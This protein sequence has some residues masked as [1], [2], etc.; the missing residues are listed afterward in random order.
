MRPGVGETLVVGASLLDWDL[1]VVIG[2]VD[3]VD[4][5]RRGWSERRPGC[6]WRVGTAW[7]LGQPAVDGFRLYTSTT[8]AR[9]RLSAG[10]WPS[11]TRVH[12]EVWKRRRH[13]SDLQR[14]LTSYLC[15]ATAATSTELSTGGGKDWGKTVFTG[16][17]AAG[18]G[19]VTLCTQVWTTLW[20]DVDVDRPTPPH[21]LADGRWCA[22]GRTPATHRRVR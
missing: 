8:Q 6:A 21:R 11:S 1:V 14:L 18:L 10:W 20:M 12:S 19:E 22:L 16:R 3:A 4:N 17:S 7:P 15:I 9:R 5:P 2:A 13:M